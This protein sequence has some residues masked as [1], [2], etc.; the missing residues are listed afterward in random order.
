M[1]TDI[2]L[3]ELVLN[4]LSKAQYESIQEPSEDELYMTPNVIDSVPTSESTNPVTSGGVYSAI[5]SKKLSE[6]VDVLLPNPNGDDVLGFDIDLNKWVNKHLKQINGESLF[7]S[8]NIIIDEDFTKVV[9]ISSNISMSS[10]YNGVTCNNSNILMNASN[11]YTISVDAFAR[12]ENSFVLT[13]NSSSLI[14][15]IFDF[16]PQSISMFVG[17]N[18]IID[19]YKLSVPVAAYSS[20]ILSYKIFGGDCVSYNIQT[21]RVK[22]VLADEITLDNNTV[23]LVFKNDNTGELKYFDVDDTDAFTPQFSEYT[24]QPYVRFTRNK[25]GLP[26]VIHKNQSSGMWGQYNRYRLYCDTTNNGGFHWSVTINDTVKSGDVSWTANDTLDSIVTQLNTGAVDTYLVFTH[27][28]GENFIRIRKGGYSYSIFTI[29]NANNT[30]LED[31]SLYTRIGGVQQSESHRDWQ[32]QTVEGMFPSS[33]FLTASTVLYAKNGYNLSYR[34]GC[35]LNRYKTYWRE[36]GSATYVADSSVGRMSEVGFNNLDGDGTASHQELY[37]KYQGSWD[38]YMDAGMVQI[39]D[40]HTN[41]MEYQSYDNGYEQTMFL[42]SV[43]TMDFDGSYIHAF[44]AAYNAQLKE[45]SDIGKFHLPTVHEIAVFM[46]NDTMLKINKAF[47]FLSS[48][49]NLTNSGYYWSVA[50]YSSDISWFYLGYNGGLDYAAKCSSI[51]VRSLAY[52]NS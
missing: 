21:I 27:N 28:S 26:I 52:I 18:G 7:G 33:G 40:N 4:I 17:E 24:I 45:D 38:N 49:T 22:G 48:P 23:A 47:G 37:D 41:G 25:N 35:N 29:T 46:N 11:T 14:N 12:H 36:S 34:C 51:S 9:T 13:N 44:P 32:A 39:D 5:N 30:T 10:I 19:G 50:Q 3:E 20:T 6:L 43:E 31:L 8:G 42:A 2:R 16:L 15:I 1:P